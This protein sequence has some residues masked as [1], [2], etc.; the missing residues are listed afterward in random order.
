MST[1]NKTYT[2][3]KTHPS[4]ASE[5]GGQCLTDNRLIDSLIEQPSQ[6]AVPYGKIFLYTMKSEWS[7]HLILLFVENVAQGGCKTRKRKNRYYEIMAWQTWG[8]CI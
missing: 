7:N 3:K 4:K 1:V 5:K 6:P 8:V 2:P